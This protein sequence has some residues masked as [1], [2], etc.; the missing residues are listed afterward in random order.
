MARKRKTARTAPQTAGY[1]RVITT[2]DAQR[3]AAR[4][5]LPASTGAVLVA[6]ADHTGIRNV[7]DGLAMVW[8]KVETIAERVGLSVRMVRYHLGALKRAG[9]LVDVDNSDDTVGLVDRGRT[10][11]RALVIDMFAAVEST[12]A[13]LGGSRLHTAGGPT[14]YREDG[15]ET[16]TP[17]PPPVDRVTSTNTVPASDETRAASMAAIRAAIAGSRHRQTAGA[18]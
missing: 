12:I 1:R 8:P 11:I 9:L 5:G 15:R 3:T 2:A 10:R 16:A 13:G 17:T 18:H 4:H 6:L 7:A 14:S